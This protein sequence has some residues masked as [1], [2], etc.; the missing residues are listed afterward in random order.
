LYMRTCDILNIVTKPDL[1]TTYW[2]E[3]KGFEIVEMDR[4]QN[5]SGDDGTKRVLVSQDS[6]IK[7]GRVAEIF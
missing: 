7:T 6:I 4:G 3:N 1:K 2:L 5:I